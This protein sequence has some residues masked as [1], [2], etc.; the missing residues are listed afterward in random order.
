[1][2]LMCIAASLT[3]P[4]RFQSRLPEK[5]KNDK[6]T[7]PLEQGRP[8][9]KFDGA[10]AWSFFSTRPTRLNATPASP[11]VYP[12]PKRMLRVAPL[13]KG[14][15]PS[16]IPRLSSVRPLELVATPRQKLAAASLAA[17][18]HFA[19]HGVDKDAGACVRG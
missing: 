4:P 5:K 9:L 14:N 12:L 8:P 16:E 18:Q 6:S 15:A 1:M 19:S 7:G 17:N 2:V 11:P 3:S 13:G 10:R